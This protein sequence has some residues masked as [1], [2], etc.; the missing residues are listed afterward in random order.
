MFTMV[1]RKDLTLLQEFYNNN[2]GKSFMSYGEGVSFKLSVAI[3]GSGI[4][5]V[6]CLTQRMQISLLRAQYS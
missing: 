4:N 2:L 1:V 3:G 5:M 6:R